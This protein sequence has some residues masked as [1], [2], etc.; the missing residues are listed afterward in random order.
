MSTLTITLPSYS[1]TRNGKQITFK[2]PCGNEDITGLIINGNSYDLLDTNG[3]LLSSNAFASDVMVSA[4]LDVDNR[5]AY[6]QGVRTGTLSINVTEN[7]IL[8]VKDINCIQYVT[9]TSTITI[10]D[11]T[12]GELPIGAEF[13]IFN[14]TESGVEIVGENENVYFAV[15]GNESLTSE[16][17]VIKD[18]YSSMILKQISTNVWSVQGNNNYLAI[19]TE[20]IDEICK[21]I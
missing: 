19:T 1:T 3:N 6:F 10:P 13:E 21:S 15:P 17:Q 4:L 7:K 11:N 9:A 8:S 14:N 20:E 5:K 16:K 12:S 18:K 2:T